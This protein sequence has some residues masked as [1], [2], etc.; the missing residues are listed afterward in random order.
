M[1][2]RSNKNV[3]EVKAKMNNRINS[4]DILYF[5]LYDKKNKHVFTPH[6]GCKWV[7]EN[8][9]ARIYT[10]D[11]RKRWKVGKEILVAYNCEPVPCIVMARC[12]NKIQAAEEKQK[13]IEKCR[14]E[15]GEKEENSDA[16]EE[17]IE[18]ANENPSKK[19]KLDTDL[20]R[21]LEMVEEN[22]KMLEKIDASLNRLA[23]SQE[24]MAKTF[25]RDLTQI[26]KAISQIEKKLRI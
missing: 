1:N 16:D 24:E 10:L 20:C 5:V 17:E 4:T 14:L 22:G 2:T 11:E 6:I 13:A 23:E 9:E 7:F 8:K 3:N 18:A 25:H 15:F 21:L 19:R 12:Y 26:K